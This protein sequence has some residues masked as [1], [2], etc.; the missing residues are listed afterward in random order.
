MFYT[1]HLLYKYFEGG[2]VSSIL[3]GLQQWVLDDE[4]RH[5]KESELAKY[6]VETSGTH[7]RWCLLVIFAKSLYIVSNKVSNDGMQV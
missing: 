3:A 4:E 7:L 5:S 6:L 1:P 2:K